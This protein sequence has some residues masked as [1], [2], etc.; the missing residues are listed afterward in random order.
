[1][2]TLTMQQR[3]ID[4]NAQYLLRKRQRLDANV[5]NSVIIEGKR[6]LHFCSNDYLHLSQHVKI[7][8]ALAQGSHH[9]GLGSGGSPQVSGYTKAHYLLE[10]A[11]ADFSHREQALLFNSGYHANLGVL[12]SLANRNSVIVADK[13]NH[14]SLIDGV[15]LSRAKHYRYAHRDLQQAENLL[16]K[17]KHTHPLLVSESVFSI[18]GDIVD[19]RALATLAKMH[20]ALLIV[21]DAHG[22]GVLG[23]RGAGIADYYQL[24]QHDL[25]CL[26]TPL[27]KALGGFGAIVSGSHTL[28]QSLLQL[29]RTY[30]Y[31]TALPPAICA[32]M[33]TALKIIEKESW[34][35]QKLHMLIPFFIKEANK[36]A[37]RLY[38]T[39]ATPIKSILIGS[40]K[41]CLSLQKQLL[42]NGLFVSCI[43]PP[44]VPQGKACLR[45]SLNCMHTEKQIMHL[46]DNIKLGLLQYE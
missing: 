24:S 5:D 9:H 40:N 7:K 35:R 13:S 29:A 14:A 38:S 31:S 39:D 33:L 46:L 23:E 1:M 22:I 15:I 42:D 21:D 32:A 6:C 4:Y 37:L 25:P 2:L 41:A 10:T 34:R 43:R 17:Y 45:I 11:F 26:I 16:K 28:I 27:G 18:Q 3:L 19:V 30:R 12:T 44:T 20:G 8:K 36:R